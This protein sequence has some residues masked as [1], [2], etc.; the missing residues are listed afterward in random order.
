MVF[1]IT[2]VCVCC[3]QGTTAAASPATH[4]NTAHTTSTHLEGPVGLVGK[5]MPV[6]LDEAAHHVCAHEPVR[7][8]MRHPCRASSAHPDTLTRCQGRP[9]D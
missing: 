2:C 8:H 3:S 6:S 5:R 9:P 1:R 4:A 7:R